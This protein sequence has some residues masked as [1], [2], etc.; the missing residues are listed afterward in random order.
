MQSITMLLLI[1]NISIY[2]FTA[3]AT[4][5]RGDMQTIIYYYGGISRSALNRGLVYTP[6]S[7]LF[8]HGSFLHIGFNMFALYQLGRLVEGVYG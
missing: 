7:A 6:I 2:I 4:I 3:I 1:I 5:G 8:L